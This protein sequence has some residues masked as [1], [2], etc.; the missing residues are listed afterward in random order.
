MRWK[1]TAATSSAF[2]DACANREQVSRP[3]QLDGDF[4][5]VLSSL[6]VVTSAPQSTPARDGRGGSR[7]PRWKPATVASNDVVAARSNLEQVSRLF[8][9]GGE[10]LNANCF[11]DVMTFKGAV[12]ACQRRPSSQSAMQAVE[13]VEAR[14]SNAVVL[15]RD[16]A[17]GAL[18]RTISGSTALNHCRKPRL[19]IWWLVGL[20]RCARRSSSLL[21]GAI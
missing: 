18:E 2:V 13:S 21:H 4:R 15:T 3:V 10:L 7:H 11:L 17:I 6:D 12:R 20:R 14:G 19:V 9:F 16:A 5:Q 8:W 1:L